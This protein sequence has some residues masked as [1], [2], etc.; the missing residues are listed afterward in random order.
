MKNNKGIVEIVL[1]DEYEGTNYEEISHM[2][3]SSS[4]SLSDLQGEEFIIDNEN[5]DVKGDC[6]VSII[7][8]DM[9]Y[10]KFYNWER[11]PFSI[12]KSKYVH[13]MMEGDLEIKDCEYDV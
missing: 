2:M 9:I 5:E 10:K 13:K 1:D 11:H 4:T 7:W 6:V 12:L 3:K 8:K